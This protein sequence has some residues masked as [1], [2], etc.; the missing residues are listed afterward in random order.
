[1]QLEQQHNL[2]LGKGFFCA[3]AIRARRYGEF[4]NAEVGKWLEQLAACTD[5][6][7]ADAYGE[8][9]LFPYWPFQLFECNADEFTVL[10]VKLLVHN[11]KFNPHNLLFTDLAHQYPYCLKPLVVRRAPEQLREPAPTLPWLFSKDV[12]VVLDARNKPLVAFT[13]AWVEVIP[14]SEPAP[15]GVPTCAHMKPITHTVDVPY[16]TS[17][18]LLCTFSAPP[19]PRLLSGSYFAPEDDGGRAFYRGMTPSALKQRRPQRADD[20]ME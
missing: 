19:Q 2:H 3:K 13:Y 20:M 6:V 12:K 15:P 1:M 7:A 8:R 4:G 10:L 16:Q 18:P 9:V 5:V 14:L 17:L 11:P